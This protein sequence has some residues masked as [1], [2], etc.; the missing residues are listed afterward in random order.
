MME[1]L[2]V[3]D[4][5]TREVIT[6][7]FDTLLEE[8]VT[9]L[10]NRLFSCLVI[11]E[12]KKPIGI[13]TERDLVSIFS[14]LLDSQNWKSLIVAN[15]M[16]KDPKTLYEDITL[17]EAVDQMRLDGIRHAPIVDSQGD[18]TGILTQ[19]DVIKGFY[20]ALKCLED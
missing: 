7:S 14:N 11:V 4:C 12:N 6:C 16:T 10:R 5:M 19:T 2:W 20:N 8:V 13:I 1:E 15:Y 3:R 18:L 17:L 9:E